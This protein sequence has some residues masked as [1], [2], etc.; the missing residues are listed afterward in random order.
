[1]LH[2]AVNDE[3]AFA[4]VHDFG[5]TRLTFT[6]IIP[7]GQEQDDPIVDAPIVDDPID[8]EDPGMGS[9]DDD[10]VPGIDLENQLP[11]TG[12]G[13][14]WLLPAGAVLTGLGGIVLRRKR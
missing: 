6:L 2:A 14:L 8:G 11:V 7:Q 5:S 13:V 10:D 9:G 4:N 12:T 3:T 1:M